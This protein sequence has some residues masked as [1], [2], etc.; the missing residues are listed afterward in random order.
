MLITNSSE[1]AEYTEACGVDRIFVDMEYLGKED[2]QK[3]LNLP[4]NRHTYADANKIKKV[5]KTADLMIR[6]NPPHPG[7]QDEV[8]KAIDAGADCIMLPYFTKVN[9]VEDFLKAVNGRCKTNLLLE[10]AAALVRAESILQLPIN[11]VHL[12]LNDLKLTLKLDFLYEPLAGGLVDFVSQIARKNNVSFGFGGIGSLLRGADIPP[13]LILKEHVRLGSERVILSRV[14]TSNLSTLNEI[15]KSIDLKKEIFLIR[16]ATLKAHTRTDQQKQND[17]E[18]I[19]TLIQKKA[20]S[21][22]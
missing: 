22:Q 14:F 17:H 9:E 4:M 15:E 3:N 2:R 11:E 6:I 20:Y 5:L 10:T 13:D 18:E 7:T 8:E 1:V 12:G 19:C 21:L 16:E